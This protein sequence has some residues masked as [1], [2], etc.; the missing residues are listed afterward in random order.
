MYILVFI[1]FERFVMKLREADFKD[2]VDLLPPAF[3][4]VVY[5]IGT[6][7]AFELVSY[8]GGTTF[9]IG[10]NKRK[11]GKLLHF[12]LAEVVGEQN[13]S[14]IETAFCGKRELYIPKCDNVL[15]RLRN[16]EI[17]REFD[18]LTTRKKYPIKPMLAAKNLAREWNISERWVWEILNSGEDALPSERAK[19]PDLFQ[20]A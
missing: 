10:Q 11:A 5:L 7:A 18:E 19:T 1:P 4:E 2:L 20:A 9:P 16:R 3:A 17:R 15:R 8:Y 12:A 14:R 13:A 6:H